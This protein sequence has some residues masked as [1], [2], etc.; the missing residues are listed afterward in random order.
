[1]ARPKKKGLDYFPFDVDFFEDDKIQFVHARFSTKGVYVA[2][3]L[4]AKVYKE[5]GYG[6]EW[7]EDT[8]LLFANRVGDNITHALVN[9]IVNELLKRG[10][11]DK[12]I[13]KKFKF[14]TSAGIQ[15][16][17][18]AICK[19]ANRRDWEIPKKHLLNELSPDITPLSPDIIELSQ[20]K[21]LQSKVKESKVKK[22]IYS[23]LNEKS[24]TWEQVEAYLKFY[25]WVVVNA[26]RIMSMDEPL[27]VFEYHSLL[28]KKYSKT[29]IME[30]CISMQN[31][32]PLT[33]RNK[34]AYLTLINWMDRRKGDAAQKPKEQDTHL[35]DAAEVLRQIEERKKKSA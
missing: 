23:A 25:D 22:S 34:S 32:K 13:F 15:K 11:F 28:E 21:M 29:L 7:D 8:A 16:R 17:Y 20:D 10:F 26:K 9:D 14:L 24:V 6:I 30:T 31:F 27:K 4:L 33:E 3:K 35:P 1:M 5:G 12:D 19:S 2:I 18:T